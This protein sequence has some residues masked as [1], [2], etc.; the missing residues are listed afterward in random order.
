MFY[1]I[2]NYYHISSSLYAYRILSIP[3]GGDG[4]DAAAFSRQS[5][6]APAGEI[7]RRGRTGGS[8]AASAGDFP[9]EKWTSPR[10]ARFESS[11]SM[12]KKE[13]V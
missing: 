9:P 7:F 8:S 1:V 12:R 2:D 4:Q 13:N 6:R 11:R 10:E 5:R 3:R